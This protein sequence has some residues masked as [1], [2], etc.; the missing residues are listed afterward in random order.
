MSYPNLGAL[1]DD[2]AAGMPDAILW[3]SIDD[4]STLTYAQ[5][6]TASVRCANALRDWGVDRG[7]HVAVMLPNVEAFAITWFAAAR[8]GAV[9]VPVNMQYTSR[10]LEYVL[11]DSDAT[12]LVIDASVSAVYDGIGENPVLR[13]ANVIVHGG[14]GS[15]DANSW[16]AR[17]AAA[18]DNAIEGTAP[19][20][21]T[22]LSIQY[23]SGST[24]FPKGC[25]LTQ[26]YWLI[27]AYVRSRQGPAPKRVLIDKPLSYMGS[28][29]RLMMCFFVGGTACVARSF[30]LGNLQQRLVDHRIDF[31]AVTDPVAGLPVLPAIRAQR[32]AW[33]SCSGLS[34]GLQRPLEERFGA[35]V[36]ELYGMTEIG[37]TLFMPIEA[38]DMSGSG[39]C[40][41]P[42]PF[43]ECRIVGADGQD[44]VRGSTGEL[45]ARGRGI[46]QGYYNKPEA[47]RDAFRGDWF[48]TG[49]VFR[50]DDRGYFYMEGRIK[51]SVRRSGENISTREVESVCAA[52]PGVA[53][54]AVIGV[55][56]DFR[57]EE[58]KVLVELQPGVTPAEASPAQLIAHCERQLAPFKVPRYIQYI[59]AFPRTSSGKIAKQ[60]IRETPVASGSVY[61]RS[62][63]TWV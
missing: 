2:A 7:T 49:D 51:D 22:L 32:F 63:K 33:I 37:S 1:A 17:F 6:A 10:E 29:W 20:V 58:V 3:E 30:T 61:D 9:L 56:D 54:A 11:R 40:G 41:L 19:T 39:S 45:W 57:G 5:F 50:Q 4:G 35:P 16:E 15:S 44:V 53:E 48:R 23:T 25:M 62:R 31:F 8:L 13:P 59:D 52:L 46:L 34:K 12:F 28:I 36:R 43:R 38:A 14:D 60:T 42:A 21:D 18:T 27:L 26:D 24:G 55:P 47:T